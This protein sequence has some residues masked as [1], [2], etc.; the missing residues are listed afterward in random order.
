MVVSCPGLID[1]R[2][3]AVAF[4]QASWAEQQQCLSGRESVDDLWSEVVAYKTE[5][6]F[7][8]EWVKMT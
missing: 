1:S 6:K 7:R 5:Q 2:V 4:L 8:I 3:P